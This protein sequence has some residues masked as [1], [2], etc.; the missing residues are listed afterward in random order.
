MIAIGRFFLGSENLSSE[1]Q[2]MHVKQISTHIL[3]LACVIIVIAFFN[4]CDIFIFMFQ[5]SK[6]SAIQLSEKAYFDYSELLFGQ[7]LVIA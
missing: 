2:M 1:P 5:F 3:Q 7:Q 4:A 6:S